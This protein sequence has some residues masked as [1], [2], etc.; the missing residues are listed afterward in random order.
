VKVLWR[1]MGKRQYAN[2]YRQL[3]PGRPVPPT[4]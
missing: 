1:L 4:I 2:Q 3:F